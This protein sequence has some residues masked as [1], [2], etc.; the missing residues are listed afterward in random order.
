MMKRIGILFALIMGCLIFMDYVLADQWHPA[1]EITPGTSGTFGTGDY[2]FPGSL[3]VKNNL[4][5]W[6]GQL[7]SSITGVSLGSLF[8]KLGGTNQ[9]FNFKDASGND[10]LTLDSFG[11]LWVKKDVSVDGSLSVAGDIKT[12]G[13]TFDIVNTYDSQY[14]AR[15]KKSIGGFQGW[16]SNV[17]FI[18][19]YGDWSSGVE[20]GHWDHP[21]N[22][23]VNGQIN[24]ASLSV[25]GVKSASTTTEWNIAD[26]C[27][28]YTD[29]SVSVNVPAGRYLIIY[30]GRW[31]CISTVIGGTSCHNYGY[32]NL[33]YAGTLN[34]APDRNVR[35]F[36]SP[37]DNGNW[38]GS[39]NVIDIATFSQQTT[40]KGYVKMCPGTVDRGDGKI[41]I[42][43]LIAIPI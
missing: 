28:Y 33:M 30:N 42:R 7:G 12:T 13:G 31:V 14:K 34:D 3:T 35:G 41:L 16:N 10:L 21:S 26:D 19:G 27:K 22:L 11:T 6:G 8:F 37:R 5:F 2:A 20:V 23:V 38:E 9:K 24:A 17:L 29:D 1:S 39:F 18:N 32:V 40:I 43:S 4:I 36:E 15:G 25:S